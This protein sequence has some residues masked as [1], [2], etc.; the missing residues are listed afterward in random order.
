MSIATRLNWATAAK[1][2]FGK[3]TEH[4]GSK[5]GKGAWTTKKDAKKTSNKG[6][7]AGGKEEVK[8]QTVGDDFDGPFPGAAPLF[9]KA[10]GLNWLVAEPRPC[11]P[12]EDPVEDHC[13]DSI[14]PPAPGGG[15]DVDSEPPGGESGWDEDP[16]LMNFNENDLDPYGNDEDD[17]F[18]D[19][20]EDPM[21]NAEPLEEEQEQAPGLPAD[22]P[23][24]PRDPSLAPDAPHQF[25]AQDSPHVQDALNKYLLPQLKSPNPQTADK[26]RRILME[27]PHVE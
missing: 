13:N 11:Y 17:D 20:G 2:K 14:A 18:F 5:R 8:D 21:E 1:P 12:S 10:E 16:G 22:D 19:I 26:A 25:W 23:H 6:R 27:G 15:D 9:K 3:S 24:G 4:S 7:R